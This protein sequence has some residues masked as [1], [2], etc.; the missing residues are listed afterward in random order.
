MLIGEGAVGAD[1]TDFISDHR[2]RFGLG[3]HAEVS[4]E[5]RPIGGLALAGGAFGDRAREIN[6]LEFV[7]VGR[8]GRTVEDAED[9]SLELRVGPFMTSGDQL[10]CMFDRLTLV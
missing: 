10:Y 1:R 4:F 8:A 7:A 5:L 6:G 3:D 2:Y 9:V